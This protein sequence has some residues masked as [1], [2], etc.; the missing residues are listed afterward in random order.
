MQERRVKARGRHRAQ[1]SQRRALGVK[2]TVSAVGAAGV[3]VAGAAVIGVAPTLAASPQLMATLHYLRGTNIGNEPTE[4]QYRDFIGVVLDG[5]DTPPPDAPYEKVPYNAGFAPFSHGG[6]GDLTYNKSVKQ[7]VEL[8]DG[9]EPASGDIIFGFSQGAVVASKYKETHTGN[10]YVLVE[11]PSKANGGVMERFKG[12]TI[13]FLDVTFSGAT[14]NNGDLTIDVARQYDGWAD[15]PTYLWNPVAVANAIVGIALVHG[16]TQ[17]ELTAAD[18]EAAEAAGNDYYQYDADSNT[19]Y[20]VIKTYPVPLLIP[21][22]TF[23]PAPVI[24]ALDAPLRAFIETA[25]DRTDYSVPTRATLFKPWGQAD[26]VVTA[27]TPASDDRTPVKSAPAEPAASDE[28]PSGDEPPPHRRGARTLV[29]DDSGQDDSLSN[30][31]EHQVITP[32]GSGGTE[33]E[34]SG[35]TSEE[36]AEDRDQETDTAPETEGQTAPSTSDDTNEHA[37]ADDHTDA[38]SH[39]PRFRDGRGPARR[40]PTAGESPCPRP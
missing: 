4:Q 8:L 1:R 36:A 14:P 17:T 37:A 18:L 10:T 38:V 22:E 31:V 34:D 16:N 25:Y 7:G 15:F 26:S 24:A 33:D 40:L 2:A 12:W 5:T 29:D 19:K 27:F 13:P 32:E 39:R 35:L 6:F 28:V 11:N 20:Y 30:P 3:A 21:L 9:Q 23:L